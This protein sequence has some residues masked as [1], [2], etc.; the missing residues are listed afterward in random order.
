MVF[1]T[2]IFRYIIRKPYSIVERI[3]PLAVLYRSLLI[4]KKNNPKFGIKDKLSTA[5]NTFPNTKYLG[6]AGK[7]PMKLYEFSQ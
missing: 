1:S 3:N 5:P 7:K 2:N 6:K 4:N